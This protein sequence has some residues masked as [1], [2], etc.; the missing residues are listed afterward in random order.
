MAI[1]AVVFD[2]GGVLA[3]V[4]PMDFAGRWEPALGLAAGQLGSA[5]ADVW[6]AGEI[7][8]VT[9]AEVGVAPGGM[10]SLDNSAR[11]VD[12]ATEFGIRAVLSETNARARAEIEALL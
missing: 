3:T 2:V 4:G 5:M 9:V 8:G 10:V 1:K 11:L 12:S 7:G 6:A